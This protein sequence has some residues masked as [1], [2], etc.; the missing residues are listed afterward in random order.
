[1][2]AS[3][4]TGQPDS[5]LSGRHLSSY[6]NS[7]VWG[8][9]GRVWLAVEPRPPHPGS[10][11][12]SAKLSQPTS[13]PCGPATPAPP[14]SCKSLSQQAQKIRR[15]ILGSGEEKPHQLPPNWHSQQLEASKCRNE[16]NKLFP[17]QGGVQLQVSTQVST[18]L[19]LFIRSKYQMGPARMKQKTETRAKG[20]DLGIPAD[21]RL[22]RQP[23]GTAGG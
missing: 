16:L 2:G 3:S 17:L 8:E 4:G 23:P 11:R 1:M 5:P 21:P 10:C 20:K 14:G 18:W 22:R 15:A 13:E 7:C 6:P 19:R 9:T 12:A